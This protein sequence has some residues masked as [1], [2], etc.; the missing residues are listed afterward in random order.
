METNNRMEAVKSI[1]ASVDST[2]INTLTWTTELHLDVEFTSGKT[3]RYF[4]VEPWTFIDLINSD[5]VG[6]E[7]IHL[8]KSEPYEYILLEKTEGEANA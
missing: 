1:K 8:I 5:S 4:G 6:K 2:Q 7:F 3:Y